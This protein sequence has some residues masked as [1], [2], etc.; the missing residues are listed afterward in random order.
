MFFQEKRCLRAYSASLSGI[1]GAL[2]VLPV[3]PYSS[4]LD[5]AAAQLQS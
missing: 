3:L 4:L 1:S 5:S 2:N